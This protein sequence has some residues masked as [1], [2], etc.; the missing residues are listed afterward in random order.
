M[1]GFR[2]LGY[3]STLGRGPRLLQR[4]EDPGRVL[5]VL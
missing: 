4:P 2:V 5:D 3:G 1:T